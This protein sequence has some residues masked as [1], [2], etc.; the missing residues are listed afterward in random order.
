[1]FKVNNKNIRTTSWT[2]FKPFPSTFIVDLEQINVRWVIHVSLN[3][4]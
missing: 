1:M 4:Y 3:L 2:Y